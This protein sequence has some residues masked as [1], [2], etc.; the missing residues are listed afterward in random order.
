MMQLG[1]IPCG[2]CERVGHLRKDCPQRSVMTL[3]RRPRRAREAVSCMIT[4]ALGTKQPKKKQKVRVTAG[5]ETIAADDALASRAAS[6]SLPARQEM[7]MAF[8]RVRD[9]D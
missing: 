6:W 1:D 3:R 9:T 4:A 2:Y 7:E 5:D 8:L